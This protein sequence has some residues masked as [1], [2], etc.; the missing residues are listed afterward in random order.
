MLHLWNPPCSFIIPPIKE[1]VF[2]RGAFARAE[3]LLERAGREEALRVDG[4]EEVALDRVEEEVPLWD[5]VERVDDRR[6][7][8]MLLL[9]PVVN[10]KK[11]VIVSNQATQVNDQ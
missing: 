2:A 4:R 8:E 7:V 10:W 1:G 11:R 9:S 3:G 5:R 6:G